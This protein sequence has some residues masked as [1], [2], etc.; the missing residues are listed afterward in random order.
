MHGYGLL[1]DGTSIRDVE[2]SLRRY[3]PGLDARLEQYSPLQ[4]LLAGHLMAALETEYT[5]AGARTILR[6]SGVQ[7][8]QPLPDADAV[9]VLRARDLRDLDPRLDL[10]PPVASGAVD[11]HLEM[12]KTDVAWTVVQGP[13]QIDWTGVRLGQI[14]TGYT[15]HPVLGFPA[16]WLDVAM[17]RTFMPDPPHD[18]PTEPPP[19]L[20]NGLDNLTGFNGGHGTKMASTIAGRSAADA[21]SGVAPKCPLVP[22]RICNSVGINSSQVQFELAVRHLVD[23]AKVKVI[24]VSLGVFPPLP[25]KAMRRAVDYAYENGVIM[26]CAAGNWVNV[27]VAPASLPRTLAVAAV[28]SQ[29]TAWSGTSHGPL[30]DLSAPGADMRSAAT[31]PGGAFTYVTGGDGTS[32]ATAMTTGA[33]ALWLVHHRA[34]LAG[35]YPTPWQVVEAFKHCVKSSARK[36]AGWQPGALGDGILDVLGL[37]NF[38]LPDAADLTHDSA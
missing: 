7:R 34:E 6:Q 31:T 1:T 20:G 29:D 9:A 8:V 4:A 19:E 18:G 35:R 5:A 33:A 12:T 10:A 16:P 28:T 38:Q 14:D 23:V 2:K 13:D 24:N 32:Y 27:V 3:L 25:I 37:L 30:V 15:P 26:V 36:P 21:F 22:V 11:W 17:A